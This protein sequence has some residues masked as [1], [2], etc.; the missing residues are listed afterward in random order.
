MQEEGKVFVVGHRNPDTDS[1]CSAIAYASLRKQQGLK[2][3]RPARAGNI[4]QQTQ[5]ILDHL[6]VEIPELLTDVHPRVKDVVT[7][8]VI[9][10]HESEPMSRAIELYH[11]HHIR[12]L[13]VVNDDGRAKG[14][15]MLK[16]A[17]EFFLVPNEPEKIRRVTASLNSIRSCLGAE[18]ISLVNEDQVEQFE[19]YV[20]ARR[21]ASFKR[22]MAESIPEKTILITGDRPGI[23]RMAVES[24]IRL[25]IISGAP[26]SMMR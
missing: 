5:F 20:G 18:G 17:T 12:M 8:Q 2:G 16:Q 23:Q 24:G 25:L 10:I 6:N 14:L 19:L 11:Q 9:S 7:E 13:P 21:E 4:N 15:L 22:W 1:I 3:V 26:Q